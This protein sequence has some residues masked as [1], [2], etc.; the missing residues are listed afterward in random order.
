MQRTLET[1]SKDERQLMLSPASF[2]TLFYLQHHDVS[3]ALKPT[4]HSLLPKPP[5]SLKEY[6]L[7]EALKD[8]A[9]NYLEQIREI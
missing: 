3:D 4:L 5:V 8:W 1:P 6:S 9:G 7:R 2:P